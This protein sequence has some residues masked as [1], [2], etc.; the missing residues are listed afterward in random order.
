MNSLRYSLCPTLAVLYV[1][2]STPT[3]GQPPPDYDAPSPSLSQPVLTLHKVDLPT[4]IEWGAQWLF[5][6]EALDSVRTLYAYEGDVCDP[7]ALDKPTEN[8]GFVVKASSTEDGVPHTG[9]LID[10]NVRNTETITLNKACQ[11]FNS[12]DISKSNDIF[13]S[14]YPIPKQKHTGLFWTK[15]P[16]GD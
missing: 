7:L 2:A 8:L 10:G 5:Y 14:R 15:I 6:P 13:L 16:A 1:I 4:K 11:S 3:L 9:Q 12:A